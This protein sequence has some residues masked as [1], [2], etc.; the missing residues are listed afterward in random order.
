M[1]RLQF[2]KTI[3]VC[4]TLASAA[5]QSCIQ[6]PKPAKGVMCSI[7][8]DTTVLLKEKSQK[9]PTC[10][11]TINFAYL[12]PSAETDTI[13]QTINHTLQR[14]VFGNKLESVS[15]EDAV[16]STNKNYITAYRKDLLSYYEE[17]IKKGMYKDR[18]PVSYNYAFDI[19]SEI[20]N[21][22]DSIYNYSVVTYEYTGG[23]HPN[24]SLHWTNINANSGKEIKK[25][26][27]FKEECSKQ[28]IELIEKQ[29]LADVN[30]RLE[31]D[32]ITSIQGLWENGVL[33]DVDLY[34]PNNFL[35]TEEGIKFLYNRY[36]IAPYVMGDFQLTVPYDDIKNY[37]KL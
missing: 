33:L 35:I 8:S 31:T 12:R 32:T 22:H 17:D 24:T 2:L 14:I 18:M 29:L 9:S 11:I 13:S 21:V 34:V 26:D 30:N 36:E 25:E 10:Q 27:V 20:K 19:K 37:I 4:G 6:T 28:I 5:L 3:I 7:K 23:A 16:K 15:P 1:N